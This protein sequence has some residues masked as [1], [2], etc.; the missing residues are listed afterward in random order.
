[1]STVITSDR[2][3]TDLLIDCLERESITATTVIAGLTAYV[4]HPNGG[5]IQAGQRF[6]SKN[7]D[8]FVGWAVTY[9]GRDSIN[10]GGEF[11]T[12]KLSEVVAEIQRLLAVAA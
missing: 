1:V 7:T 2:Q 11:R 8:K 12:K 6:W 9:E 5:L 4:R 10:R 3:R